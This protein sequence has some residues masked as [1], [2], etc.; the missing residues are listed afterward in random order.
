[1]VIKEIT[2]GTPA[3]HS[4]M[5]ILLKQLTAN[6]ICFTLDDF[7]SIV[8]SER[9]ILIGAFDNNNLVGI[10]TLVIVQIPTSKNGRIEDVVV[11]INH[12]G[13]GIGEKLTFE[14]IKLGKELNISKLFL[15]SNPK[16]IEAN[17]LYQ[18]M[19]FKPKIT[20]TYFYEI[21]K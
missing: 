13:K 18:K 15:T 6:D 11:D 7:N 20:N 19:G 1:M 3:L 10:L 14:A 5:L 12:R 17:K 4:R 8:N 9:S 16:R 21:N 2:K